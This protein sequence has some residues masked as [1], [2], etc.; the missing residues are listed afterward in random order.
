MVLSK[1]RQVGMWELP[2]MHV[3]SAELGAA[4][5]RRDAFTRIQQ[6]LRVERA[7]DAEKALE[8]RG[9][10]LRA[11][12]PD[13]LDA[14]AVLAD[15]CGHWHDYG[16][17]PRAGRK[18]GHATLRADAAAE[19]AESLRR[20]GDALGRVAQVAPVIERLAGAPAG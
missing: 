3:H 8:H 16:K 6:G 1:P 13:L 11:H 10:K 14:N 9:R 18:V 4:R 20:A 17:S 15:P 12:A 5:E 2:F 19:L 7:L